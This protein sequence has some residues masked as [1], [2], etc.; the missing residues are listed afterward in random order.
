LE[1]IDEAIQETATEV[2]SYIGQ[3]PEFAEIGQRMLQE[4][5]SGSNTSLRN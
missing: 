2:R 4:W 1:R 5:E 3:R